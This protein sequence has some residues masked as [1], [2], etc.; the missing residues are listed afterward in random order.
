MPRLISSLS[1][2]IKFITLS[3]L[4]LIGLWIFLPSPTIHEQRQHDEYIQQALT[5]GS[6]LHTIYRFTPSFSAVPEPFRPYVSGPGGSLLIDWRL[7]SD[8]A[9]DDSVALLEM[10]RDLRVHINLT[11]AILKVQKRDEEE[12]ALLDVNLEIDNPPLYISSEITVQVDAGDE[13]HI[14]NMPWFPWSDAILFQNKMHG[15]TYDVQLRVVARRETGTVEIWK[16][17]TLLACARKQEDSE[18]LF[19][20]DFDKISPSDRSDGLLASFSNIHPAAEAETAAPGGII[21]TIKVADMQMAELPSKTCR[22]RTLIL[23]P[24]APSMI[25]ILYLLLDVF[26][27]LLFPVLLPI[28]GAYIIIV[29]ICWAYYNFHSR[30]NATSR[31]DH[32]YGSAAAAENGGFADWCS[33]FWMTRHVYCF[34]FY[35]CCYCRCCLA[36][37]RRGRR[38]YY[39]YH[40]YWPGEKSEKHRGRV[41]IWGPAGPVYEE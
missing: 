14:I 39:H 10:G 21:S 16:S 22:L 13:D 1:R 18:T 27:P 9:H 26:T 6:I 23:I 7:V 25:V 19:N 20:I 36:R 40:R 34:L 37:S 32:E 33:R 28:L 41:V 17:D 3:W 4:S 11:E 24:L 30:Y 31:Y 2:I 35:C 38:D 5:S 15:F 29:L 12:K 8:P